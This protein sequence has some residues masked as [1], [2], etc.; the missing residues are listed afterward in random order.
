MALFVNPILL[1]EICCFVLTIVFQGASILLE[2]WDQ[3]FLNQ[4]LTNALGVESHISQLMQ[5]FG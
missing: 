2:E 5:M 4:K 1:F 3:R